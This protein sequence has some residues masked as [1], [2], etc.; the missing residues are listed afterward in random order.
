MAIGKNLIE[1]VSLYQKEVDEKL[2]YYNIINDIYLKE[3]KIIEDKQNILKKVEE[4]EKKFIRLFG[5]DMTK[6]KLKEH[7]YQL[8][9]NYQGLSKLN[10]A[11]LKKI[12]NKYKA[13]SNEE[14]G[15]D[16]AKF[17]EWLQSQEFQEVYEKFGKNM[18]KT[19]LHFVR[20]PLEDLIDTSH[21]GL[22]TSHKTL[23]DKDLN[24]VLLAD[25]GRVTQE[26]IKK[27]TINSYRGINSLELKDLSLYFTSL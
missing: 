26:R 8:H 7:F 15:K 24:N 20:E 6:D 2:Q 10:G 5:N 3:K 11:E 17:L 25:L 13:L 1:G 19:I 16:N 9:I 22:I 12:V 4:R 23:R 21:K 14:T 27:I 18:E